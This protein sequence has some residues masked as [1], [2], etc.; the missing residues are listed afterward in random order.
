MEQAAFH[1]KTIRDR[2]A[3]RSGGGSLAPGFRVRGVAWS[4]AFVT[5]RSSFESRPSTYDPSSSRGL[6]ND[7]A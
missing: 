7:S 6:S 4:Y 5:N 1:G 2:L 3:G